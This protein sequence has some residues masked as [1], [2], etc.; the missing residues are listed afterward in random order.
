[1]SVISLRQPALAR[2]DMARGACGVLVDAQ[3]PALRRCLCQ[4]VA[5]G[6]HYTSALARTRSLSVVS[7]V[8][9]VWRAQHTVACLLLQGACTRQAVAQVRTAVWPGYAARG[10]CQHTPVAAAPRR[11]VG[12]SLDSCQ[13]TTSLCLHCWGLIPLLWLWR[14]EVSRWVFSRG[15]HSRLVAA[16]LKHFDNIFA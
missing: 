13:I 9:F 2:Q 11:G 4:V 1:M 16:F 15:P 7:Q 6:K 8:C 10:T 3:H 14:A 5:L 12:W